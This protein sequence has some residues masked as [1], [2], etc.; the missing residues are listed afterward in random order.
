MA[1]GHVQRAIPAGTG[2]R[3]GRLPLVLG[4][5]V[6]Y[7]AAEV[8]G[9]LYSGSLALLA[10]AG[11]MLS[12]VAALGLSLFAF[13]VAR[14]PPTP[15]RT[16]G[17]HRMEILAAL[18][19]GA[20]L[21]AIAGWIT[22]EAAHRLMDPPPVA[23]GIVMAVAFGGLVINGAGMLLL[24]G[25]KD[26]SL[27]LRGAWLHLLADALG[28][29]AVVVSG[30]LVWGFGWAWADPLASAL[31]A[32]LVVHAAWN[33]VKEA[34]AV[35]MEWA[36]GHVDV[37]AVREAMAGVDGVAGVHDLHV[38]TI[39]SGMECLSGH[40]VARA[41]RDPHGLLDDVSCMLRQRFGI[42]HATIQVEPEGF[43]EPHVCP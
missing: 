31:V 14:R 15:T 37:D 35:L 29:V 4:L 33:L 23:G 2:P 3:G 17:Y 18:A 30:A 13:W 12:D 25:D 20:A 8:A 40:V 28:S 24:G 21:V 7:A 9:G 16:Y 32:L 36:P 22:V 5:T 1:E 38:W 39:T 34:A 26:R 27:N 10:D 6:L 19:N 43:A 41:G 42:E 11:H